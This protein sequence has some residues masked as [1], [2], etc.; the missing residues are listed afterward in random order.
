M[1]VSAKCFVAIWAFAHPGLETF[2]YA[3]SAEDM[4]AGL[5]DSVFEILSAYGTEG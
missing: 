3:V 2:F 5:D 4:T 1:I